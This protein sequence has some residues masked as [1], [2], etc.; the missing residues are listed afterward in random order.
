MFVIRTHLIRNV[1]IFCEK[2]NRQ[3]KC[4]VIWKGLC[5]IL[6]NACFKFSYFITK[7]IVNRAKLV[8]KTNRP[9]LRRAVSSVQVCAGLHNSYVVVI[10]K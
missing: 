2:I 10:Q 6:T 3:R 4:G 7:D 9:Y 5:G 8:T 1:T